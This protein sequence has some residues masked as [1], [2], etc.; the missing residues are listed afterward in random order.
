[1]KDTDW[2]T[3]RRNEEC[4]AILVV[5]TSIATIAISKSKVTSVD[6]ALVTV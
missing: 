2:L 5:F 4:A 6:D 3:M 1:M